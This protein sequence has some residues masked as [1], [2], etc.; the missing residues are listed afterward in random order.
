MRASRPRFPLGTTLLRVACA[1]TSFEIRSTNIAAVV[2]RDT[3][4]QWNGR[5]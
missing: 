3:V 5:G 1:Y 2:T 4:A